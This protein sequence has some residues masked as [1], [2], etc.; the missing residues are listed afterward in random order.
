MTILQLFFGKMHNK[1]LKCT[2]QSRIQYF[3][4]K[5]INIIVLFNLYLQIIS[6]Y[7]ANMYNLLIEGAD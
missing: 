4:H 7:N 6:C 5:I 2:S 3:A 1:A